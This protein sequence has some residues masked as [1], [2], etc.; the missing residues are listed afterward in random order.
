[1]NL[2][3]YI[4]KEKLLILQRNP[5]R[6]YDEETLTLLSNIILYLVNAEANNYKQ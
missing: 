2:Y 6:N 4:I 1:M 3:F 5:L